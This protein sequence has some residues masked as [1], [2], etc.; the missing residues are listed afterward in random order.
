[1]VRTDGKGQWSG[2]GGGVSIDLI[3]SAYL[4]DPDHNSGYTEGLGKKS[5]DAGHPTL[6]DK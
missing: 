6:F 4:L 1:M 3:S 5:S 2:V